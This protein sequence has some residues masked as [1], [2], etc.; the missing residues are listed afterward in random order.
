MYFLKDLHGCGC[1]HAACKVKKHNCPTNGPLKQNNADSCSPLNSSF[2]I[3][4]VLP[5]LPC[6]WSIRSLFACKFPK[7]CPRHLHL[8]AKKANRSETKK[9]GVKGS[10]KYTQT[11]SKWWF[12]KIFIFHPENGGHDPL[13]KKKSNG[14]I[15]PTKYLLASWTIGIPFFPAPYIL[16]L[17]QWK[18]PSA[19]SGL[20]RQR[21]SR[22]TG[23]FGRHNGRNDQCCGSNQSPNWCRIWCGDVVKWLMPL[24]IPSQPSTPL[25]LQMASCGRC[26]A[27][28]LRILELHPRK[29][30]GSRSCTYGLMYVYQVDINGY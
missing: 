2:F 18:K 28:T 21:A 9:I 6:M 8:N 24:S 12:Q 15:P 22:R 1:S 29:A 10:K 20:A 13:K 5:L 11:Y 3:L 25:W 19:P 30:E 14:L 4:V 23:Q 16:T 7:S 17:A 26:R 27:G